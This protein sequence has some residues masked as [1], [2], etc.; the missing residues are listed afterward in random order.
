MM[1]LVSHSIDD[2]DLARFENTLTTVT[3]DGNRLGGSTDAAITV[4]TI[5]FLILD[6][7]ARDRAFYG[8]V[9]G[10]RRWIFR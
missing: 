8:R 2:P 6:V 3:E 5:T 7:R 4:P 1:S 10:S 9:Y